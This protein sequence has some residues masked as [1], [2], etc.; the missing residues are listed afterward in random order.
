MNILVISYVEYITTQIEMLLKNKYNDCNILVANDTKD[1]KRLLYENDF[2]LIIIDMMV[3]ES[4]HLINNSILMPALQF[5]RYVN[6][7]C[8]N[9]KVFAL[10]DES[11]TGKAYQEEVESMNYKIANCD[12]ASVEWEQKLLNYI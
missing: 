6:F 10:F 1:A 5:L 2:D 9:I 12:V 7:R 11:E 4:L 3:Q 8:P